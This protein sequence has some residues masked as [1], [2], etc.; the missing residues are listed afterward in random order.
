[1]AGDFLRGLHALLVGFLSVHYP[2]LW[3]RDRLGLVCRMSQL[4]L[5]QQKH[6]D[7][8][9]SYEL[10]IKKINVHGYSKKKL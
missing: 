8:G 7:R 5:I 3:L 1:M 6:F 10:L 2:A 4:L 9:I